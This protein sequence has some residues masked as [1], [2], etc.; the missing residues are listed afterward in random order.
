MRSPRVG[1]V[2]FIFLLA[3]SVLWLGATGPATATIYDTDI[4]G[5]I[6][7]SAQQRLQVERILEE[8]ARD[9]D[10]VLRKNGI[11]PA[12]NRPSAIKLYN[13]SAEMSEVGRRVR[14]LLAEILDA[15]QLRQY[16]QITAE[17]EQRI[18][19]AFAPPERMNMGEVR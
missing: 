13:A 11:D 10:R 2:T 5:R 3:V 12:D 14:S 1:Q 7:L 6:N 17:V 4:E 18:R 8:G 15:E 19:K 16:D 9:L